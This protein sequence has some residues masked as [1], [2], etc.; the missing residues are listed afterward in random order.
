MLIYC[1]EWDWLSTWNNEEESLK[2]SKYVSIMCNYSSLHY[3]VLDNLSSHD[4]EPYSNRVDRPSTGSCRVLVQNSLKPYRKFMQS[5]NEPYWYCS[6][7]TNNDNNNNNSLFT[8]YIKSGS[9]QS[10]SHPSSFLCSCFACT[11]PEY[12]C[13]SAPWTLSNTK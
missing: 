10:L 5:E 2:E 8:F 6:P 4:M 7:N 11:H 1:T 13:N 9:Q 12:S 3:F